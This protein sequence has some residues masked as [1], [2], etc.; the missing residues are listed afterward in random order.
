MQIRAG[1]IVK[2]TRFW[3][4]NA[5]FRSCDRHTDHE[6]ALACGTGGTGGDFAK[7]RLLLAHTMQRP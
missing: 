2:M 3:A 4:G 7:G 5:L 1:G 6:F